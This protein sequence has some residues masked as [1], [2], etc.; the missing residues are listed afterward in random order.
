M[1]WN[2]IVQRSSV[3]YLRKYLPSVLLTG[4]TEGLG[5]RIVKQ[6]ALVVPVSFELPLRHTALHLCV[7]IYVKSVCMCE[8][9]IGWIYVR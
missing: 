8:L 7:C 6:C 2:R 9:R 3:P 1:F 5:G 4:D